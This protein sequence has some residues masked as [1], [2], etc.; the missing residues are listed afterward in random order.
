MQF[1]IL[2]LILK[3]VIIR[4]IFFKNKKSMKLQQIR[5]FTLVELIIVISILSLLATLAFVSFQSYVSQS[6][7][8]QR[9]SSLIQIQKSIDASF[10][11]TGKYPLPES[12]VAITLSGKTLSYQ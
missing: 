9:L 3:S 5:A 10:I 11:T 12:P 1:F 4:K 8:T 2:T 6:K 7:D